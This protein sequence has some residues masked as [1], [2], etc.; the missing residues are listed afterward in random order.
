MKTEHILLTSLGVQARETR[1]Q[2]EGQEATAL[3]TP[4]ALVRLL[5]PSQRPN[6]VVAVI[7]QEAKDQTWETFR[8]GICQALGF[9]P[10][11]VLIPDG[12][13]SDEI[14]Q[15]L[16]KVARCVPEGAELTLDVTQGLRH[17][18]FIFYALVLYL[19]SLRGVKVRGAYYGMIEGSLPDVPKPIVDLRPLLELPE[20]FHAVRMFRDQGT[21]SP[22]A[23][24]LQ[25]LADALRQEVQKS[26]KGPPSP[27]AMGTS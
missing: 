15:I 19:T 7:T 12:N 18:P 23:K 21:T 4:L 13:S 9:E 24:L 17:F 20:W 26:S 16:E 3:L 6:R 27:E 22:I 1:Y 10:Q 11:W 8:E 2:W 25:P 5:D 14:R